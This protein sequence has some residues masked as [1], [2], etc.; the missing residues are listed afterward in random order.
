MS[1]VL[2]L[3]NGIKEM[4]RGKGVKMSLSRSPSQKVEHANVLML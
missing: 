3:C 1:Y 4:E 2:M